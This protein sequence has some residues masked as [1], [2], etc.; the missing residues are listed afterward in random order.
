MVGARLDGAED[1]S[2]LSVELCFE[3]E[4]RRDA[5][6]G[7]DRGLENPPLR[8]RA[9]SEGRCNSLSEI[10]SSCFIKGGDSRTRDPV[11]RERLHH[12]FWGYQHPCPKANLQVAAKPL[13]DPRTRRRNE[14]RASQA[15]RHF[16][17]VARS[18]SKARLDDNHNVDERH[19]DRVSGKK[20]MQPRLLRGRNESKVR[21][22]T[23][24]NSA[25]VV[26]VLG[27]IRMLPA[28]GRHDDAFRPGTKGGPMSCNV[29]AFGPTRPYR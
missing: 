2:E 13:W 28:R 26:G 22:P 6:V 21:A 18:A 8:N 23:R 25:I 29:D 9:S 10:I 7:F 11:A 24:N 3:L 19:Q 4:G 20:L 5:T 17:R 15:P 16:G 27:R 1:K 14:N 12:V